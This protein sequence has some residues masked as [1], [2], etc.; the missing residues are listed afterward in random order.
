L[1]ELGLDQ[2][3]GLSSLSIPAR[4]FHGQPKPTGTDAPIKCAWPQQVLCP[5]V[6]AKVDAF[7]FSLFFLSPNRDGPIPTSVRVPLPPP[8]VPLSAPGG[9]ESQIGLLRPFLRARQKHAEFQTIEDDKLSPRPKVF[10][11]KVPPTGKIPVKRRVGN[12]ALGGVKKKSAVVGSKLGGGVAAAAAVA[13]T[14]VKKVLAGEGGATTANFS[15]AS[16]ATVP[17][18]AAAP[19]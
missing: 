8:F 12:E 19:R 13:A 3:L 10:R 11:P 6:E 16:A 1:R 5:Y 18:A 14:A 9:I 4:L 2:E 15:G 7:S 17:V